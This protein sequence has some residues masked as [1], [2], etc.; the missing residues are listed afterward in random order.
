MCEEGKLAGMMLLNVKGYRIHT[1]E[2]L[3]SEERPTKEK[4]TLTAIPYYAWANRGE[5]Q[6]RVW[7]HGLNEN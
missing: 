1:S 7:M 2:T 3:Y 6:M 5:N 4:E